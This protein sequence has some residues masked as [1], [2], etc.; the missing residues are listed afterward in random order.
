MKECDFPEGTCVLKLKEEIKSADTDIAAEALD[1]AN[2]LKAPQHHQSFGLNLLIKNKS[3]LLLND[4][5]ITEILTAICKVSLIK[6]KV[7]A[8]VP[9]GAEQATID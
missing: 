7:E 2:Y 1:M 4:T 3:E 5:A 6:N 8:E 9:E